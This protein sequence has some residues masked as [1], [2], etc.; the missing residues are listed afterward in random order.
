MLEKNRKSPFFTLRA[1][2]PRFTSGIQMALIFLGCFAFENIIC[3]SEKNIVKNDFLSRNMILF[4]G[5]ANIPLAREIA[6]Y[7]NIDL[8]NAR[9]E[10]F[11]DGEIHISIENSVR[12]KNVFVL[13]SN[14][15]SKNQSVNDNLM[16][17]FLMV[18]AMKRASAANITAVIPYYGYAR[19]DRK[20]A[21]RMPISA[22][23]VAL[24]LEV[25]GID[26]VVTVDLHSGQIQGFFRDVPV[27]NLY[28]TFMFVSYFVEKDL[29]NVVVVSPDAGG[30]ERAK[31]FME[32]LSKQ[33]VSSE[34]ALISKQRA[35][36]GVVASMS[37]IGDV[38]GADVIIVDD[39][40]DTGG[41]LVKAAKLLKDHG[42]NR[43]F[44]AITHAVFSG[45][46]LEKIR[47][48]VI[49]EMV[50]SDTIPLREEVPPNVHCI[51]I[52]PLLGEA[53][54]RIMNDES[55]SDLFQ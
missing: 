29:Q 25:A 9:V 12:N 4:S 46:A 39:M 3:S 37:L 42:A 5:N 44:V 40:C 51:S 6:N 33:G 28:A 1:A 34:M 38:S 35:K 18:R 7:L 16:E 49:D 13:Q 20:T 2:V 31:I 53:I 54:R 41:T 17:L 48:S 14:C 27:D 15:P 22:A 52:A 50:I 24:M 21:A 45:D 23:D 19:Q 55:V 11:N 10:K 30:V 47:D 36:A 8:G 32:N 26:R 43:V